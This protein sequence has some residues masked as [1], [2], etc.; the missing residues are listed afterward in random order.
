MFELEDELCDA[1]VFP[2]TSVFKQLI[3]YFVACQNALL[4]KWQR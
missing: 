1:G 2:L 3:L 4:K